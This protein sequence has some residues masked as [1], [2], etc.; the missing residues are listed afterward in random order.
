MTVLTTT[1]TINATEAPKP[2]VVY[3]IVQDK[4]AKVERLVRE[5]GAYWQFGEGTMLPWAKND[6]HKLTK[7]VDTDEVREFEFVLPGDASLKRP[8]QPW[9]H[10]PRLNRVHVAN[11]RGLKDRYVVVLSDGTSV[12]WDQWVSMDDDDRGHYLYEDVKS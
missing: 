5:D 6:G 3:W 9:Q 2:P 11:V 8:A 10:T 12:D 4:I 1:V 7:T